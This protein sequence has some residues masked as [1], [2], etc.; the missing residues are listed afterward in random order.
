MPTGRVARCPP[1][2]S[3][4]FANREGTR[5]TQGVTAADIRWK[6]RFFN[7]NRAFAL[8]R[9]AFD[10]GPAVLSML[11]REGAIQ[12]FE[13]TFELAWKVLKDYLEEEGAIVVPLTPRQVIK[14]AF[15]AGIL[16]D[17]QTWIEMLDQRN[18]LSH[19]YNEQVFIKAVDAIAQRYL[20]ALA[21]MHAWFAAKSA[22]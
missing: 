1:T 12:R 22:P 13:Y 11:E 3:C 15:A 16:A 10:R 18:L 17:G 21:A 8:L 9:E 20:P 14:D 19:N 6:Q 4:A 7:F 2:P 5:Y